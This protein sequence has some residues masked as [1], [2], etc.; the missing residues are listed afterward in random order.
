MGPRT[1]TLQRYYQH[2]EDI[3]KQSSKCSMEIGLRCDR[4]S[5]LVFRSKILLK[6]TLTYQYDKENPKIKSSINFQ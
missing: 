3:L 1:C 6:K 4:T 5:S 2:K